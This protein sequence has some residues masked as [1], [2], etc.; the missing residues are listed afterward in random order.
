MVA[1]LLA[2]GFV[3]SGKIVR[4]ANEDNIRKWIHTASETETIMDKLEAMSAF[5]KVVAHGSFA[6]AARDLGLTRSTVSKAVIELEQL[7]GVRLLERTT[8][9]VRP[10]EAGL[11]YYQRCSEVLASIE[12]TELQVSRLHDEPRGVLKVNA[13]MSFST[14]YLGD[15]VANFMKSYPELKI[16]L[17]LNDRFVDPLEEGF[18]ITIRIGILPDS[19]LVARRIA[20]A[21]RMLVAAPDYLKRYGEPKVPEDLNKHHCLSYGHSTSMQRW[22][23]TQKGKAIAVPIQSCLCSNNG[24]VLR[25]AAVNGVG[26]AM[27]PTFIAGPDVRA[28]RLQPVMCDYPAVDL[29]IYALYAANRFLPAKSRLFIDALVERFAHEPDWD[30]HVRRG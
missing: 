6:E 10:T 19:S 16:E 20:P 4:V 26:V 18:D 3:S 12:E 17:T 28:G 9:R 21:R 7:L 8:R 2:G 23:L 1:P 14:L 22:Q 24:D 27:L 13:P 25:F 15:F 30:W 29:A 5:S 11:N